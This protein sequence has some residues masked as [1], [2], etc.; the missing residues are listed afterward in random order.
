M[1]L[2]STANS[3]PLLIVEMVMEEKVASP[4]VQFS[5][6]VPPESEEFDLWAAS[7]SVA[8]IHVSVRACRS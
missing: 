5:S 7:E 4:V 3:E 8:R 1:K 2:R 6:A